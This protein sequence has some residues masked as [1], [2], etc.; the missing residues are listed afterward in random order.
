[1]IAQDDLR[2]VLRGPLPLGPNRI[3]RFYEGGLLLDRF[4]GAADPR[5]TDHPEDWVGSITPAV[6]PGDGRPPDEGLSALTLPSGERTTLKA[7]LEAFPE[8]ALGAEHA[9]KWGANSGLLI[10][11]LDASTRLPVHCHPTRPFARDHFSSVFGKTE[12]W[13]VLGTRQTPGTEP[14]ILLGFKEAVEKGSFRRQVERQDVGDLR[15]SLHRIPVKP[16]DVF[17][18]KAGLPHAI[19]AGVFLIEAQE[20]TDFSVVAEWAGFPIDPED[21]HLGLGWDV[22]IDCF[23][24]TTYQPEQVRREYKMEP[25]LLRHDRGGAEWQLLGGKTAPYFSATKLVAHGELR[26]AEPGFYI[27][28]ATGGRGVLAGEFGEMSVARGDTFVCFTATREHAFRSLGE[29][30]LE[31]V[32]CLPPR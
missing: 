5:D 21:A 9:R 6:N 23:D 15:E 29:E 12:A 8:E 27:G 1:M 2:R 19:G 10:K 7:L 26:V 25:Q 18:V 11:L 4:R 16:G 28:I 22:A 3:Y 17:Y 32:R 30:P 31:V 24:F 14:H 13:M 20:P